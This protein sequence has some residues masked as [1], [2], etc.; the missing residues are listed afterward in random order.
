MLFHDHTAAIKHFAICL[1]VRARPRSINHWKSEALSTQIGVAA[2]G[3]P[4]QP[5]FAACAVL[6][7]NQQ[8]AG[9]YKPLRSSRYDSDQN[10]RAL[11]AQNFT[12]LKTVSNPGAD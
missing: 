1:C 3:F 7:R 5:S 8:T 4:K 6:Y 10:G 2:L 9:M 12:G 11:A